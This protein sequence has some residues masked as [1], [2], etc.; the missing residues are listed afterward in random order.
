MAEHLPRIEIVA[1]GS[2][3][4]TPYFEDTDSP[5]IV[6]QLE[7][8]GLAPSFRTIMADD[9]EILATGLRHS[10][11]RSELCFIIGGLGP[12]EDDRTR[13]VLARL[14]KKKLI[15][16]E[17]ILATIRQRFARRGLTMPSSNLKQAYI[18]EGALVLPNHHGTAPGQWIEDNEKIIVLLP[19]P[20]Q[21]LKPM[22]ETYVLPRLQRWRV[23]NVFQARLK[24]TGI[25]ES[26]IEERIKDL[27]PT[28]GQP[29]LT[30]LAYPGQIEIHLT[31]YSERSREEAQETVN[32]MVDKLTSR[33]RPYIFSTQGESL[34]EVVGQLLRQRGETLAVAESCTGGLLGHRLTNIPGSSD[35]FRLSTVVYSNEAKVKLLGVS[36][37]SLSNY[38]AV[39]EEV[40]R[41]MALGVQKLAGTEHALAITGIAGPGGGTATKPV[42]LVYTARAGEDG[43]RVVK[44]QFLGSRELVK[45]QSSQKALEM[46]WRYLTGRQE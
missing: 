18:I 34:E 28:S 11:R 16:Q 27:Y 22:F 42:G 5:Y 2:E 43:C 44:N 40:A 4:L 19:G 46:L 29:R 26:Q 23:Y 45:F 24:L 15:L 13:E 21:E 17:E 1:V 7:Q 10:L 9:E 14:L 3:L 39:S 32:Q 38:G 33:L 30:T 25:T 37:E 20:P 36:P 35:Y 12:T 31:A 6:A 41:E 8:L